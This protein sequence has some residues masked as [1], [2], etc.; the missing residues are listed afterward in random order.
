LLWRVKGS[1]EFYLSRALVEV[2]VVLVVG[3]NRTERVVINRVN[4]A[5]CTRLLAV[6]EVVRMAIRKDWQ[7]K[8]HRSTRASRRHRQ[9]LVV[10]ELVRVARVTVLARGIGDL[11]LYFVQI[12]VTTRA[13]TAVVDL[14]QWRGKQYGPCRGAQWARQ[15]PG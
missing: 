7:L 10:L 11:V 12:N 1:S 2:R 15:Q 9:T 5:N 4:R 3:N 14:C 13:A 6:L 8:H